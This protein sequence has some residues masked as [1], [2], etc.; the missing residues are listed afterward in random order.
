MRRGYITWCHRFI[1]HPQDSCSLLNKCITRIIYVNIVAYGLC[2]KDAF[3]VHSL[4]KNS[5]CMW[6]IVTGFLI[7]H[8]SWKCDEN[9]SSLFSRD[10]LLNS[11]NM[12]YF[13]FG[14]IWLNNIFILSDNFN[15]A[16]KNDYFNL[17]N[18]KCI[19]CTLCLVIYLY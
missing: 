11:L 16:S 8:K 13:L 19:K 7:F 5:E 6:K 4:S 3:F 12:Q 15:L 17:V 18:I 9:F 1:P 2:T 10:C 14:Y